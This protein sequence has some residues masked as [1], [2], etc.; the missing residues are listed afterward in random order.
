MKIK[1]MQH[2]LKSKGIDLAVFITR[3]NKKDFNLHYFAQADCK[4]AV[5]LIPKS[6]MPILFVSPL[7]F[8]STK[9][10][11]RIEKLE[12]RISEIISKRFKRI[13]TIGINQDN[14]TLNELKQLK[15]SIKAKYTDISKICSTLRE[16]KTEKEIRIIKRACSI[17]TRI[18]NKCIK[19]IN[20]FNTEQQIAEFLKSETKKAGCE[21]SWEPVVASGKNAA[22]PHHVPKGKLQKGFCIIDFGLVYKGYNSDMTRTIFLGKPTQKDRELYNLVLKAQEKAIENARPEV[23]IKKLEKEARKTLGKYSKY[24]IHSL[25]HGIGVHVHELPRISVNAKGRLKQGMVFTIE[26]GIYIK[27][28]LGIRIEDDLFLVRGGID[29]L[30]PKR[31]K[32]HFF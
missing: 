22:I 12:K 2:H 25:G 10:N 9:A 16:T 4:H 29:Y 3:P 15:K 6:S 14:I 24:F 21:L 31:K 18:L 27:G 5:L 17:T 7:E 32:W 23:P 1:E 13:K 28:K 11:V 20:K 8:G 26:P 30:T 19:N